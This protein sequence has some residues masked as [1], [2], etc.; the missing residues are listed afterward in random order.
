MLG[1]GFACLVRIALAFFRSCMCMKIHTSEQP[2]DLT[3]NVNSSFHA[4]YQQLEGLG[5]STEASAY[6]SPS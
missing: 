5:D 2:Q 4:A 1:K 6:S 3:S